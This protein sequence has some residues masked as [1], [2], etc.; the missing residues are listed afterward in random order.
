MALYNSNYSYNISLQNHVKYHN[1]L[2]SVI[3]I[4]HQL[5]FYFVKCFKIV[6]ANNCIMC[7]REFRSIK[8]L[9]LYIFQIVCLVVPTHVHICVILL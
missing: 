4:I 1:F 5:I 2:I 3:I 6:S 8:S 7:L 9:H